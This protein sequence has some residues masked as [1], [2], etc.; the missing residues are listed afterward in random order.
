M[1]IPMHFHNQ[2]RLAKSRDPFGKMLMHPFHRHCM[3]T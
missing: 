1:L 2:A 3:T